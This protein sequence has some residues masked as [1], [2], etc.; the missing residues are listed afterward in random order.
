[1]AK[2]YFVWTMHDRGG[3]A[4]GLGRLFED[5]EVG[6]PPGAS[7]LPGGPWPLEEAEARLPRTHTV[8]DFDPLGKGI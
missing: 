7:L 1:M 6:L 4:Y 2:L 3:V 8:P 5:G